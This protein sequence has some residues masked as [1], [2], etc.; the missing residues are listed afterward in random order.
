M[1]IKGGKQLCV[2]EIIEGNAQTQKK[3]ENNFVYVK[4]LRETPM[5]R[6]KWNTIMFL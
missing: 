6:K 1:Y 3:V 5:D 4:K 2:C